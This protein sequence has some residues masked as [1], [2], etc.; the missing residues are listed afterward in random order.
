MTTPLKYWKT[1]SKLEDLEWKSD[2]VR[3]DE[4]YLYRSDSVLDRRCEIDAAG[5]DACSVPSL[6]SIS[7]GVPGHCRA[8]SV[9]CRS[10]NLPILLG[11]HGNQ[12]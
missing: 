1:I 6:R 5:S 8:V 9:R 11:C 12:L 2:L 4:S 3:L 7:A 10:V